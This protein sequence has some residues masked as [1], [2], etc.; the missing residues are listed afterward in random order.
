ME[1]VQKYM[2][3]NDKVYV[4]VNETRKVDGT[5]QPLF[6][7]W[8]DGARYSIDKITD[9]R[10]AASLKAGGA[11]LRYTVKVGCRETFLFLEEGGGV[12]RWFVE[13]KT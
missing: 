5:I 9:I 6:L 1:D 4:E 8:E 10:T 13:R 3:N 12:S 2:E 7:V 11:G